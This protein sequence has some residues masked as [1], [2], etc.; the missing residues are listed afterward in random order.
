MH[1]LALAG[2]LASGLSAAL[3]L[4]GLLVLVAH[5]QR[6]PRAAP[7]ILRRADGSWAVPERGLHALALGEGTSIG[8]FWAL[9]RL[10][11]DGGGVSVLLLKD[12][13]PD[14]T[15]RALRAE[16]LRS[17]GVGTV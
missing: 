2:L 5:A 8:A 10:D 1:A 16:L 12:Q 14:E 4:G 3:K 11:G 7:R 13:L 9:L 6:I 15:W 17:D